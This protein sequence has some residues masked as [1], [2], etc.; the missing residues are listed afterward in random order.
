MT[1]P[2]VPNIFGTRDWFHGRQIFRG[3]GWGGGELFQNDQVHYIYR[4]L[5]S[6]V[7][8]SSLPQI[9]KH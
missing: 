2:V 1:N 5:T 8:T 9:I 7:I 6:T 4:A 3:P